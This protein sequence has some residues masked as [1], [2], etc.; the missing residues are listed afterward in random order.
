VIMIYGRY[1]KV[2]Q[3]KT[4]EKFKRGIEPFCTLNLLETGHSLLHEKNSAAIAA[5][6]Q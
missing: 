3:F 4:G 5:L 1:D 2:I 6:L